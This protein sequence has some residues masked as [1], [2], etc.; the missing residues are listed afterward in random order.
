MLL[1][2]GALLATATATIAAVWRRQQ[3]N[4]LRE[5]LQ[6]EMV[7][8]RLIRQFYDLPF[9]GMARTSPETTAWLQVNDRLCEI[10]G[11]SRGE[12][13]TRTSLELTH[14]D[15]LARSMVEFDRL[16][17][18]EVDG[19]TMDK[20]FIR[21]DGTTVFA[22]VDVKCV[23]DKDGAIEYFAETVQ[24]ITERKQA[25]AR[26][27]RLMA[28]LERSNKELE[29]FAYIASHDLQ[30]P[31]RM[32]SSYTQLLAERYGSQLDDKARKYIHYAVDGA[33]RMQGL[34]NDLLAYSR[35]GRADQKLESA[36]TH[37]A[38][39]EA[40]RLL[41]TVIAESRALITTD[42][43]PTVRCD[44][45]RLTQVFQNLLSNAIKF[46]GKDPPRIHVS[47][48]EGPDEWVFAVKD[49]GI[50]I[51]LQHAKRVFVV[52]QRLHAREEY[53]G[54]GIGLAICQRIVQR[55]GGRIW[56]E[57]EP[58]KG[59]TFFFTIPK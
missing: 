51:E 34:I 13:R 52:F 49:N 57:S 39:G 46:H 30:E 8:A 44:G 14:P 53:P 15:D 4:R 56:F 6:Q 23:R 17:R 7:Q 35:V 27:A 33:I 25:E 43:L 18:G 59:T 2:V 41:A 38:F 5:V 29:E 22:T 54:T 45:S 47:A 50:G 16:L 55:G 3:R 24:D 48:H 10:L 28:D 12:L 26:L 31:L 19:F 9:I 20:R 42:D 36:D 1:L 11:Y 58:G 21:Q 37:A 32:V 40:L